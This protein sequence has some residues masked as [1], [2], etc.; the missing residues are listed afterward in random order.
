MTPVILLVTIATQ[1]PIRIIYAPAIT[2]L[3]RFTVLSKILGVRPLDDF[4]S[5]RVP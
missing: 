4:V 3:P 1:I 2:M 5:T